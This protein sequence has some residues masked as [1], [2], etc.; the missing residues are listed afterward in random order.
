MSQGELSNALK[1]SRQ[2]VSKWET[3]TSVPELDKLVRMSEV[4]NIS[5]DELILGEKPE[6]IKREPQKSD[7]YVQKKSGLSARKTV[8]LILLGTGLI[9]FLFL[10]LL[11]E[12]LSA[13]ILSSPLFVCAIICLIVG[14]HTVLWCLWALYVLIYT[15]LRYATGIRFWWIFHP[16]IYRSGLEVHALTAWAMSLALAA[17]VIV[18]GRLLFIIRKSK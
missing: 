16:G 1:V 13:L 7:M 5:L 10:S 2:S 18:T 11:A 14:K 4:F 3:N 12:P 6:E 9:A 17:L 15:Y 8:G